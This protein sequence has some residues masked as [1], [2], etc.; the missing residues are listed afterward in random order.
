M[1]WPSGSSGTLQAKLAAG[2]RVF[3]IQFL[4]S[5]VTVG[6]RPWHG[7]AWPRSRRQ[8]RAERCLSDWANLPIWTG[9]HF[10]WNLTSP[11]I[12]IV[13]QCVCTWS[14]RGQVLFFLF[15]CPRR[16]CTK[17]NK[18]YSLLLLILLLFTILTSQNEHQGYDFL[19]FVLCIWISV[20]LC[21]TT[22]PPP[23]SP[24]TITRKQQTISC[25]YQHV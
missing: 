8:H 3:V 12:F 7:P 18:T 2:Y 14:P 15:L 6:P 24:H 21:I 10:C 25:G 20:Q 13:G 5:T 9:P 16:H 23:Y 22:L 4:M 1:G 17:I 19:Y 11:V